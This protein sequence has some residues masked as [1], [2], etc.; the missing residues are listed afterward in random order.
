MA[1]TYGLTPAEA[2][3]VER[4][5]AGA[6]SLAEVA[7]SLDVSLATVKTHLSQVFAKTGVSRQS[8][9]IALMHRMTPAAR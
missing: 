5:M 7:T 9:L 1:R 8:E 2:R 3:V 6:S 4:L